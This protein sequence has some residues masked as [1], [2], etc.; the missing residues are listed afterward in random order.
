MFPFSVLL[1]LCIN[2][3]DHAKQV[4]FWILVGLITPEQY[5]QSLLMKKV[6]ESQHDLKH[7]L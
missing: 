6:P 4:M 5:I 1:I 7:W 2:D 3:K